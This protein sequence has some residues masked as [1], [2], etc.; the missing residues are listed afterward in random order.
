M[1]KTWLPVVVVL[2]LAS[3]CN[4][5]LKGKSESAVA[6]PA[7]GGG[8]AAPPLTPEETLARQAIT[9]LNQATDLMNSVTDRA[10]AVAVAP[11]LKSIAQQ[12]QELNRR[13]VPLGSQV[14]ENPQPLGRLQR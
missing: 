8:V 3:G 10:T 7:A 11:Q 9:L 1:K 4:L 2:V 6:P 5:R 12:L 14:H 13:G